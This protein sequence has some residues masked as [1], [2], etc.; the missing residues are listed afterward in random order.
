M[1][2]YWEKTNG[3]KLSDDFKDL[4]MKMFAFEGKDRP[5]VEEIKNHPWMKVP[6][7]MKEVRHDLLNQLA[8]KRVGQTDSTKNT[9][10]NDKRGEEM[11][12]LVR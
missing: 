9:D 6:I 10:G 4:I 2:K 7:N 5:T 1:A 12:E 3:S 8:E 11:L